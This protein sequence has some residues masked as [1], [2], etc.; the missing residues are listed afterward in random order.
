LQFLLRLGVQ[1]AAVE[2]RGDKALDEAQLVNRVDGA[3]SRGVRRVE[4][5]VILVS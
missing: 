1:D 3:V 5:L 4:R 2:D